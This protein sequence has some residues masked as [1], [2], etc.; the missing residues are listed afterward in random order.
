MKEVWDRTG[1]NTEAVARGLERSGRI[2]TLG[3]AHRRAGGGVVRLRGHRP[4]QG[5][6]DRHGHRGR[7]RR[8]GRPG[9]ARAGDDAADRP[10]ELVDAGVARAPRREPPARVGGRRGGGA[11][12][13]ATPSRDRWADP[14]RGRRRRRGRDAARRLH[15]GGRR[16]DPGQPDRAAAIRRTADGDARSAAGPTP[17]G[18]APGRRPARPP[19]R[20]VVLHGPPPGG[21]RVARTASSTSSSAPSAARFP[22]SWAS[23]SRDHR[24]DRRSLRLR[25]AARGRPAGR[26]L[27]AA[28]RTARRPGSRCRCPVPTRRARRPSAVPRGRCPV[29]TGSITW[30]RRWRPTRRPRPGCPPVWASTSRSGPPSRRRCTT[31]TAGSTSARPAAPTT[32]RGRRWTP[33]ARS[34]STAARSTWRAMAWFDHQWGDFISV[35][36]GGWDWFAVNLD[37]GT[38]LTLSLVRDADGTYPLV[39]GTLVEA[40]GTTRHLDRDAFDVT[41]DRPVDEPGD[42]RRVPGRLARRDP[43]RGAAR[44]T[45]RRRSPRR[46]STRGRRPGSSTGRDRSGSRRR[47]TGDRSAARPTSS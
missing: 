11:R 39:Y 4:H 9:P 2:V 13:D 34:R 26:R 41:V 30:P 15:L 35:G 7:A 1:D 21:R 44:S 27:A 6:R 5:A 22:T 45:W 40:D 8:D 46:S 16:A 10:L 18:P 47:A 23:P 37:D 12:D 29:P 19:D 32:T 42:R 25:P 24:R 38:D 20:V 33:Q 31:A 28:A 14:R 36:G 43:R 17:R 3:G